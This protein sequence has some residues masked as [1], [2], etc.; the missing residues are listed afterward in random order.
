MKPALLATKALK[1][2][3]AVGLADYSI[4]LA[5]RS[6]RLSRPME[7]A[8]YLQQAKYWGDAVRRHRLE[9]SRLFRFVIQARP[10]A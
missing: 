9:Y 2:C 3:H 8:R 5:L 10:A 7:A 4:H 1:L 6:A